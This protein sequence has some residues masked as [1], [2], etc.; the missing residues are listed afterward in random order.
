MYYNAKASWNRVCE[1]DWTHSPV[2]VS[3]LQPGMRSVGL[4][5][6]RCN[7][8]HKILRDT[9]GHQS[10]QISNSAWRHRGLIWQSLAARH[11]LS[12]GRRRG[13]AVWKKIWIV[14]WCD[15]FMFVR[16]VVSPPVLFMWRAYQRESRPAP[17][18]GGNL[19]LPG[20]QTILGSG[21]TPLLAQTHA[22]SNVSHRV[23]ST[24]FTVPAVLQGWIELSRI[25]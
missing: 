15:L 14:A 18:R 4:G 12:E 11:Q 9:R 20:R 25:W 24:S 5:E 7:T 19:P 3:S 13:D 1:D 6:W 23:N 21:F 17:L 2:C 22:R 8:C 10:L 16:S